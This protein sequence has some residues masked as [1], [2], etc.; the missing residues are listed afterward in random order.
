MNPGEDQPAMTTQDQVPVPTS[1]LLTSLLAEASE[2]DGQQEWR[3]NEPRLEVHTGTR[4]ELRRHNG[5]LHHVRMCNVSTDSL[6]VICPK[7]VR[8]YDI[9]GLRRLGDTGAYERFKVLHVTPTVGGVK[10]GM[11]RHHH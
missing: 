11:I 2:S 4:L 5:K 1:P 6:C 3:R 9:V 10:L 8:L 7:S